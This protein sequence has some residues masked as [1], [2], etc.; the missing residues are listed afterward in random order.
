MQP[1]ISTILALD[2]GERRVGVARANTFARIASALTT[3]ERGPEI[4]QAIQKLIS[5]ENAS[6]LVVGLPRGLQGQH[7]QQTKNTEAFGEEL[8]QALSIPVKWQDEAVTSRKAEAELQARGKPYQK[9]DIDALS[10]VYI[11]EDY[12]RDNPEDS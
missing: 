2:V 6:V 9:G 1:A 3:L 12:L 7:T 4:I 10:A 5:A 11:L 8:A